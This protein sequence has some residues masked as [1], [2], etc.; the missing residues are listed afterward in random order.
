MNGYGKLC[1]AR[2]SL[3]PGRLLTDMSPL[4]KS[5]LPQKVGMC[6][7]LHVPFLVYNV[8]YSCTSIFT[9]SIFT[10][11][12]IM[13]YPPEHA[14]RRDLWYVASFV[15]MSS[16]RCPPMFWNGCRWMGNGKA[17]V[18]VTASDFLQAIRE[19]CGQASLCRFFSF[20]GVRGGALHTKIKKGGLRLLSST[21]YAIGYHEIWRFA[22][23]TGNHC[24]IA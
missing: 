5:K 13:P 10:A 4:R 23:S 16:S 11:S 14:P 2:K 1:V 24:C 3:L 22:S 20:C 21:W 7:Q 9:A 12:A 19:A 6:S 15:T 8:N 17:P 18:A